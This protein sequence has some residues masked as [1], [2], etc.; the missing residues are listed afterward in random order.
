MLWATARAALAGRDA[1]QAFGAA[2]G[3]AGRASS[4]AAGRWH[5]ATGAE[6]CEEQDGSA[7]SR[8]GAHRGRPPRRL[9]VRSWTATEAAADVED[10]GPPMAQP[11]RG[12]SAGLPPDVDPP[13]LLAASLST[14]PCSS[15]LLR[16]GN[17]LS[18][19]A[20]STSRTTAGRPPLPCLKKGR[21][22]SQ[23]T[24]C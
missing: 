13:P 2:A 11:R 21:C 1:A 16:S 24:A 9:G 10:R 15:R 4:L 17:W 5:S 3:H 18:R 23:K 8:L 22:S 20:S 19:R 14:R 12:R 6:A 7:A